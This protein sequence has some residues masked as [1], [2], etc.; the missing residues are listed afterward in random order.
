MPQQALALSNSQ[1]IHVASAETVKQI[2]AE[3]PEAFIRAAF[4]HLLS[5]AAT[6]R[7]LATCLTFWEQQEQ[8]LKSEDQ[9]RESLV[10]V[11]F[12]HNDFVTIR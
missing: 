11:L 7:E 8:E 3:G 6:T 4:L 2:A 10:R 9:V 1:L 5:R 12:N